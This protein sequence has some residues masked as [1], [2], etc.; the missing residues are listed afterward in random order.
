MEAR[1]RQTHP[2]LVVPYALDTN[3]M[4]QANHRMPAPII[5]LTASALKG[6]QE[7]C[8]AAGCTA[9]LTKPIKRDVLL[10]AIKEHS[11]VPPPSANE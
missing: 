5:A 9:Y 11:I 2:H 8:L 4:R 1:D 10:Q 3:E 7:E 6:D